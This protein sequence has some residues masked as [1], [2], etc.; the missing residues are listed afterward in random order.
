MSAPGVVIAG[1]G[2]AAQRCAETLRSRGYEAPIRIV[3]GEAEAP[4]DRPPLSKS[5]LR[6]ELE[7]D[8]LRFRDPGWYAENAVELL[9]GRRAV[10]LRAPERQLDL[11][12]GEHLAYEDL[13]IATGAAPRRLPALDRFANAL[14]LRTLADVAELRAELGASTRLAI[15]GSGFI[16]QEVAATARALGAE[17]SVIEALDLPLVGVLGTRVSR[18]LVDMHRDE[19]V[20]ML[21]ASRLAGAAGNGRV[22]RLEL[23][24]GS[25]VDTDVVIVAVG[26]APDTAWLAG[27]G[28]GPGGILTDPEGRTNVGHVFAAGDVAT[29]FDPC[30]GE[31]V[32]TEHWD[33][34]SRQGAAVARAI[35]GDPPHPAPPASF[36]SDQYGVRIQYA[37]T[38][39]GADGLRFDGDLDGRDFTVLY[40]REGRPIAALAVGRPR[41]FAALRRLLVQTP[42]PHPNQGDSDE[43][44]ADNR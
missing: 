10:G 37:G 27:A 9:L 13:V 39:T 12:R 21:L 41:E 31:Y 42:D 6:G 7:A 22:E 15:I 30:R 5:V 33:A 26:V 36:W 8:A 32:R 20:R 17:V 4:Y 25:T 29:P 28:L 43:L 23:E 11:D 34:A 2:L 35:L 3:C 14:T 38:T 18:W 19:G 1:G 40:R 16:G 44:P 24:S